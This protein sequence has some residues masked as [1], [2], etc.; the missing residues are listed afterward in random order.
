MNAD[1][2]LLFGVFALQASLI[3]EQQFIEACTLW[4]RTPD[5]SLAEI[6]SDHQWLTDEDR[7]HLEYLIGRKLEKCS[8]DL[9]ATLADSAG[10]RVREVLIEID[11]PVIQ[12]TLSKLS[13]A[14]GRHPPPTI[15]YEPASRERYTITRLHARGGIGQ[16]WL[17]RDTDLGRDVALK[18]LRAERSDN[19]EVWARFLEEAQITGQLEHPGIVPVYELVK[20]KSRGRSFYTMRFVHGRTLSDTIADYHRKRTEGQAGMLELR[21]LLNALIAVSNAVAYAHSRRVLHRDLKPQNVVLGDYGEVILLDWGLAK[22]IKD[23]ASAQGTSVSTLSTPVPVVLEKESSRDETLQGQVLGTPGYMAP[24]QAA[25]RA[26]LIDERSDVYGLGA[27]LYQILTEDP[28]FRDPDTLQVVHEVIHD[29]PARPLHKVPSTP[30]GL[31]AI[32]L[33]A[34]AKRPADRYPNATAL[35][36][37]VQRWLADEPLGVFRDPWIVRLGRWTRRRRTLV[38]GVAAALVVAMVSLVAATALLTA[39]NRRERE[40]RNLAQERENDANAN[41]QMAR[42]AID[43]YSIKVSEDK[44]LQE[45]FRPLRKELLQTAV[46]FYERF[47]AQRADD[48]ELQAELG[49]TRIRLGAITREID[50]PDKAIASYQQARELFTRLVERYPERLEYGQ[51][52]AKALSELAML[53]EAVGRQAQADETCNQAFRLR[54]RLAREHPDDPTCQYDLAVSLFNLGLLCRNTGRAAEAEEALKQ[55]IAI[56]DKLVQRY[57]HE[58]QYHRQLGAG[59]NTLGTLY[60]DIGKSAQA[61]HAYQ[62]AL[63][64]RQRLAAEYPGVA[65]YQMDAAAAHTN[66]GIIFSEIDKMP[67]SEKSYKE[68]VSIQ[69]RVVAAH[70]EMPAYRSLLAGCLDSQAN[71]YRAI[72]RFDEARKAHEEAHG[73]FKQLTGEY[74]EV[75]SYAVDF[76]GSCANLGSLAVE[77][78]KPEQALDWY[79]R[80]IACGEAVLQKESRQASAREFL[81]IAH[82]SRGKILSKRGQHVDALRDCELALKFDNGRDRDGIRLTRAEV[83]ARAGD[84]AGALAEAD[85]L[86][87]GK[88]LTG[89]NLYDLAGIY[90]LSTAALKADAAL[91]AVDRNLRSEQ[92][93]RQT[94]V[95]L[96]RAKVAG[97][98]RGPEQVEQLKK[99]DPR[100]EPIRQRGELQKLAGELEA[101]LKSLGK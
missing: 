70:P 83:R 97:F 54:Q 11:N 86:L 55:S 53:Y 19:P 87:K 18:E 27:I 2:N 75:I 100:F 62:D 58:P 40:A 99:K 32:C 47:V 8:G 51:A 6:L 48:P 28:P 52:L 96:D 91:S 16:I 94:L 42:Q 88:S 77:Q 67:E 80:A 39:A 20:E 17:A 89:A 57:P 63:T 74:P 95:L 37:D 26:D 82:E 85:E 5:R 72:G 14:R 22:V 12:Q 92:A 49:H 78:D 35:A 84:H 71:L 76:G 34:L 24:E 38:T 7:F 3:T 98:F 73:I 25:G 56:N 46:P 15:A 66:L 41:F 44:R 10:D 50:A 93:A 90:S 33:K 4:S 21:A 101:A 69:R 29:P 79:A 13:L 23:A 81:S 9:Q 36:E 30:P 68:A 64:V 43:D 59:H 31:E 1:R 45:N 65:Q 60:R 61:E